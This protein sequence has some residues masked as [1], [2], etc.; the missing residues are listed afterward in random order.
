MVFELGIS[1]E[2]PSGIELPLREKYNIYNILIYNITL[3]CRVLEFRG[4]M[5]IGSILVFNLMMYDFSVKDLM[6][7]IYN[8][9]IAC[10]GLSDIVSNN[11]ISIIEVLFLSYFVLVV[12]QLLCKLTF[13]KP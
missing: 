7:H 11:I 1:F 2:T 4:W 8:A 10:I 5:F 13:L 9:P 3:P 12:D 6:F